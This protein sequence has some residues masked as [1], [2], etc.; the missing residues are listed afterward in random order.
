MSLVDHADLLNG[1]LGGAGEMAKTAA[2][3]TLMVASA[4]WVTEANFSRVAFSG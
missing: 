3:L 2:S 1:L 4:R